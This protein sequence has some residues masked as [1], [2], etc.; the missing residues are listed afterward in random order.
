MGDRRYGLRYFT[1]AAFPAVLRPP[2]T[3]AAL[4]AKCA[5]QDNAVTATASVL[6]VFSSPLLPSQRQDEDDEY[7]QLHLRGISMATTTFAEQHLSDYETASSRSTSA[8]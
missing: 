7:L 2:A 6:C 1:T 8:S 4:A 3:T 5:V